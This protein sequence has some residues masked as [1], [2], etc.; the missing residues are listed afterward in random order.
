MLPSQCL[1]N[2]IL[3]LEHTVTQSPD[4]LWL[5]FLYELV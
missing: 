2:A 3:A 5:V 4:G 1:R